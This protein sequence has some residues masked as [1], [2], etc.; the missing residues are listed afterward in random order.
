MTAEEK[1]VLK[2]ILGSQNKLFESP[3]K[4]EYLKLF[5]TGKI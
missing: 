5:K 4:L 1:I 3:K 2:I